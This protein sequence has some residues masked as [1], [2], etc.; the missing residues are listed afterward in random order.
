M[1]VYFAAPV[2][3]QTSASTPTKSK[4]SS[5][6]TATKK[7]DSTIITSM[8]LEAFQQIVQK[9]GFE[10]TRG[11]D[12]SG[13]DETFFTFRAEGY[14]VAVLIYPSSVMLYC[15]FTDVHP[16]LSTVNEWNVNNRFSCSY[17]DKEGTATLESSLIFSGGV[18]HETLEVFIK[19]FRDSVGRWARFVLDHEK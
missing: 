2:S 16:T 12:E 13:K 1:I 9:M 8:T 14:K 10:C 3:A 15:G 6:D 17:V 7:T 5:N 18:T 4:A 19:T 11:K